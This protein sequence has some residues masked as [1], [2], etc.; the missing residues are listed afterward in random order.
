MANGKVHPTLNEASARFTESVL[1]FLGEL[2]GV[3]QEH[4]LDIPERIALWLDRKGLTIGQLSANILRAIFTL[5]GFGFAIQLYAVFVGGTMQADPTTGIIWTIV[6]LLVFGGLW[7]R[8]VVMSLWSV[9]H[10]L[11]L[12]ALVL[13]SFLFLVFVVGGTIQTTAGTAPPVPLFA[14]R[15]TI[16]L[17][18]VISM[19][20][21][22]IFLPLLRAGTVLHG[23]I[24]NRK[25]DEIRTIVRRINRDNPN[26]ATEF[27]SEVRRVIVNDDFGM[28]FAE[29]WV[30]L[31]AVF[32][33]ALLLFPTPIQLYLPFMLL[34]VSLALIFG[35][36]KPFGII[37]YGMHKVLYSMALA[38]FIGLLVYMGLIFVG[39]RV[40]TGKASGVY[41]NWITGWE[42]WIAIAVIA[43]LTPLLYRTV[44]SGREQK[45]LRLGKLATVLPY[46]LQVH[47]VD[48][49]TGVPNHFTVAQSHGHE[50]KAEGHHSKS[51]EK[52]GTSM[53][54]GAIVGLVAILM[55]FGLT[56]LL[57]TGK[58]TVS[59]NMIM[60]A[61]TV[62]FV[63]GCF[64]ALAKPT[65]PSSGGH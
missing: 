18:G 29:K 52:R 34:F 51:T 30:A 39:P 16:L 7:F 47:G 64:L 50:H 2:S 17:G 65:P 54:F 59:G 31:I 33:T 38:S 10:G 32:T 44:V 63:G 36:R 15:A 49:V 11:A 60:G 21:F 19:A 45:D 61:F 57:G 5:V 12:T 40:G 25:V 27:E 14:V 6:G 46:A 22:M 62:L 43:I 41:S 48:P 28:T 35:I 9:N 8:L 42:G 4:I 13:P 23:I 53:N 24:I 58:V 20:G 56:V 3:V 26:H 1:G 55:L 37:G